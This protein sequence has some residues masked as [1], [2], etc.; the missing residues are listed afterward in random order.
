[1]TT[2]S[3]VVDVDLK[4]R[5]RASFD[6]PAGRTLAV[7][8]PNGAGKS[9]LLACLAGLARPDSGRIGLG[10]RVLFA[11]EPSIWI[12]PHSRRVAT[13]SQDPLLF[14]H[15]SA[16]DNV[17]FAPRAEGMGKRE[18]R[19]LAT[20]WLERLDSADLADRSPGTLSGGQ[21]AR[22]ALARALA[23][24][25]ELV[26]LDEPMAAV[27]AGQRPALRHTLRQALTD[28]TALVVTHDLL[29]VALLADEVLVIEG[30]RVTEH[31]PC[32][33]FLEAP[34][35]EF[36]AALTGLN[37]V[38]GRWDGRAVVR[39]D[40]LA[41]AGE[42]TAALSSGDEAVALFR[43]NAV[44]VFTA[45]PEGSVRNVLTV[46]VDSVEPHGDRVRLRAGG[47]SAE[48]TPAAAAELALVPGDT[49]HLGIKATEVTALP[50]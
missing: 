14:P 5:I 16:R 41:V 26:L 34:R 30:G 22:V 23:A 13:L 1:V 19:T 12:P 36:G 38:R 25:P 39:A 50:A 31:T 6:V 42:A 3:L 32:A 7:V 24:D 15:L 43:P 18:A 46:P 10:E 47:L 44:T 49:V 27:D 35:S 40:G 28:R 29:D 8:G 45:R 17:A 11:D 21:A 48:I 2:S 9:S 4:D 33:R 37:L 20:T